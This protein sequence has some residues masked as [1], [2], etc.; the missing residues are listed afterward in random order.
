MLSLWSSIV[1]G[2]ADESLDESLDGSI[3]IVVQDAELYM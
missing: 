3:L 2:E 1:A